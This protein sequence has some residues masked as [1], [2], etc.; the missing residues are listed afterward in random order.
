MKASAQLAGVASQ[1]VLSLQLPL[2]VVPLDSATRR[3]TSLMR[4]WRVHGGMPPVLAWMSAGFHHPAFNGALVVA[5]CVLGESEAAS[6]EP[7][8]GLPHHWQLCLLIFFSISSE[9][10]P[11]LAVGRRLRRRSLMAACAI[12][13]AISCLM[14]TA[15][16]R[17]AMP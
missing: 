14:F 12:A 16:C 17:L 6:R 7:R 4:D 13:A 10:A 5:G 15:L 1:V 9:L 8:A 3:M 11:P 2:A